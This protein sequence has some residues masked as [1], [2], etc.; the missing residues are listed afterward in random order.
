MKQ[1]KF[2]VCKTYAGGKVYG[3]TIPPEI[4]NLFNNVYFYIEKSG[5]SIILT[6]GLRIKDMKDRDLEKYDFEDCKI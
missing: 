2:Y 5:D 3:I 1:R 6:S 4:A